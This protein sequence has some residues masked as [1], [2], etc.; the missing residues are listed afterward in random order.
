MSTQDLSAALWTAWARAEVE[1]P[2]VERTDEP[3]ESSDMWS[4][5]CAWL[6]EA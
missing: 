5:A 6:E 1:L 4:R 3:T 2:A